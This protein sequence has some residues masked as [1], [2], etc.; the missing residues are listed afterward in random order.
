MAYQSVLYRKQLDVAGDTGKVPISLDEGIA[1]V[2]KAAG[3]RSDRS[4]KNGRK[5]K[6]KDQTVELVMHLVGEE[7]KTTIA[8]REAAH[9]SEVEL[10]QRRIHKLKGSLEATEHNLARLS[11]GEQVDPGISSIYRQV[12]G[13]DQGD[14][15]LKRKRTLM[16]D[17]FRA[18]VALQKG[19]VSDN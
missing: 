19:A 1:R 6:S 7:R 3:M 16:A 4:Y 17:I 14:T 11:D 5:R 12:Q 18:N 13:L 8:A 15:H 9:D 10:L 2:K